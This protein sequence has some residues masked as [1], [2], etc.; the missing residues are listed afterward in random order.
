M[1]SPALRNCIGVN[2]PVPYASMFCGA[3]TGSRKPKQIRNCMITTN[4]RPPSAAFGM[5]AAKAMNTGIRALESAVAEAKPRW[6]RIVKAPMTAI[7]ATIGSSARPSAVKVRFESHAAAPVLSS[8]EPSEMPTANTTSVP[9]LT[10]F[11]TVFHENTPTRGSRR[12]ATAARVTVVASTGCRTPWVAHAVTRRTATTV[13]RISL[14]VIGPRAARSRWTT[15]RPPTMR[16]VSG[17]M[18]QRITK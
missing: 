3:E 6:M 7:S 12:K 16:S 8:S 9:Q 10:S 18:A 17:L 1:G 4:P 2:A 5:D 15:S 11:S 13:R 14:P